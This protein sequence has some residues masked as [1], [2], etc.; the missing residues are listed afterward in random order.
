MWKCSGSTLT[1]CWLCHFSPAARLCTCRFLSWHRN[2]L[3]CLTLFVQGRKKYNYHIETLTTDTYSFCISKDSTIYK[4]AAFIYR[5][6]LLGVCSL[7]FE[8]PHHSARRS[9]DFQRAQRKCTQNFLLVLNSA[10]TSFYTSE[11]HTFKC[12]NKKKNAFLTGG[13]AINHN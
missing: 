12:R 13:V 10:R 7:N 11:A 9:A 5:T 2:S 1:C 4:D 8:F 3:M 6:C